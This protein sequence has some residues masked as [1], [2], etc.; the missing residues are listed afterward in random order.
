M[1]HDR[2]LDDVYNVG[3]IGTLLYGQALSWFALILEKDMAVLHDHEG[4]LGELTATFGDAD[5]SQVEKAKL[6]KLHQATPLETFLALVKL[7]MP[8][9]TLSLIVLV[10]LGGSSCFIDEGLVKKHGIAVV[11]KN[12]QIIA[13]VVDGRPLAF[14]NI[15]MDTTPLSVYLGDHD[16]HIYFNVISS[17]INM[18]MIEM[19]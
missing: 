3:F 19:P 12:K 18:V 1:Y 5:M 17:P 10:D 4:F 7:I 13:E 8:K 2:Y 9:M 6:R 16:S 11:Q 15:T 14:G